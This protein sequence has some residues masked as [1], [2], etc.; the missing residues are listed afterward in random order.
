MRRAMFLL[1]AGGLTLGSF[2]DSSV[3]RPP[4]TVNGTAILTA[5]LHVHAFPGDGV[6]PAWQL[7]R[8]AKRRGI[9]VIAITNHNQSL[10]ASFPSGGT[11]GE[12]PLVIPGQEITT[13]TFHMAA[14]GVRRVVDWRLPLRQAIDAV[15]A[16]GGVAIGAHP[17]ETSWRERDL[18]AISALDGVEAVHG[19]RDRLSRARYQLRDFYRKAVSLK[20]AI[21]AIGSSDFHAI[22]PLGRCV[23]YIAVDHISERGVLNAIRRG[24]TVAS[25][26]RGT[27]VGDPDLV[28]IVQQATAGATPAAASGFLRQVA[29]VMVLGARILLVCFK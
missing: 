7:R 8:E 5:D 10:A 29:A 1:L 28:T 20:P 15:H 17:V 27:L 26:R 9:D 25:D 4:L 13:P 6:L 21:A 14:V 16:Q 11:D 19:G 3:E 18:S 23:T 12:L 24:R 2:T 22:A